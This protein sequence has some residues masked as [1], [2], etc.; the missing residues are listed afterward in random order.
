M[1]ALALALLLAAGGAGAVDTYSS[2]PG[3]TDALSAARSLLAQKNWRGAVDELRRINAADS[4]DWNNLMGF[5]LRKSA[6]PDFAA[7]ER[8][9][10]AALRI[11][12]QHRGALEYS[13][14]LFLML[15][16]LPRAEQRLAALDKACFL[17]C[18]EYSELKKAVARFKAN[19][20]RFAPE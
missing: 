1:R 3:A 13:G 4:A 2:S 7:A 8:F 10:D 18:A 14:E 5:A 17:P 15:G 16:D 12:P 6:P 19:G 11:D 20:N 9:Y